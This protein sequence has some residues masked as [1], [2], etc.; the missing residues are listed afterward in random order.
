MYTLIQYKD[1]N[2]KC[3]FFDGVK[4]EIILFFTCILIDYMAHEVTK[5]FWKNI[6]FWKY[7]S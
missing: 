4:S 5:E 1:H 2:S 7:D 6:K 3:K